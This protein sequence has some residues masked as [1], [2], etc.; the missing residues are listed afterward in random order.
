MAKIRKRG[1]SYQ[2]D[3]F[4]PTGKRVR[5]SFS[6]KKDAEAEL[7][8]RVSLIAEGR[9]LDVKKDYKTT[10]KEIIDKYTENY[11]HQRGFK[12]GKRFFIK[13]IQEYFGEETLLANIRYVDLETYRNYLK[14]KLTQHKTIRTDA[15]I[16]REMSCLRH[17]FRK[18]VEWEMIERSPFD[19]GKSLML[20]ENNKR[21]RFLAEKEITE[22]LNE[23]PGYLR[24]IVECALLT[25]MRKSEILGLK[26]DQIRNGFIYL[27]ETKPKESRQIPINDDLEALFDRI[28]GRG[29]VYAFPHSGKPKKQH[30]N[31][32]DVF[33]YNGK[34]I[35]DVKGSF[36]NAVKG[37]GIVDFKFH[38]LRHTF[39]SQVLLRGGDLKDIQEL[40]GHSTMTMTLRYAH[41]TQEHKKKAVNLLNGLTATDKG[42][43]NPLCHK[44][45]TSTAKEECASL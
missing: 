24:N 28:K 12:T 31:S 27:H 25:G 10:L 22:L 32:N 1:N 19:R 45:V 7:G 26:W 8:K 35:D 5:K 43:K 42:G 3:Y 13:T 6:K 9:Y 44:T 18:A 11:Q 30:L 29:T 36:N 16:N 34:P 4:D 17:M 14:K 21:F 23:C 37:A 39:A 2:I 33:T 41:L 40:L 15:S 38:D 20:K